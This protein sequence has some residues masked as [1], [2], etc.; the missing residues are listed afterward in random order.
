MIN[1]NGKLVVDEHFTEPLSSF[2]DVAQVGN[3]TVRAGGGTLALTVQPSQHTYSNAQI[4]DYRYDDFAFRW[5]PPL[6]M[7]V[8]A[9][10]S[11]AGRPL[12]GTQHTLND[13]GRT[14]N[15]TGDALGA[16]GRTLVGTAGFGFWNHPFSPDSRRLPH[17]P[18]AIWF[19]FASPPSNMAL[20]FGVPGAGWKAA[21]IDATRPSAIALAP[22]ALPAALL[23]RVPSLYARLY[24][25]IQ[26]R[27]KIAEKLLDGDLLAERHVY[28]LEWRADGARFAVDG[29]TVLQ[30]PF[31]PRGALGFVTWLD[32][33]YAI[34]TPQ[35]K[36]GFGIVPVAQE[37]TLLLEQVTIEPL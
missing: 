31:S 36:L 25:R 6:R 32:N 34:V 29:A 5:R 21:T 20:A 1:R 27:L 26:R 22:A 24:P 8:V 16:A 17:L 13:T 19:F 15:S 3:G 37:Q 4:A 23:M 12:S 30:T 11:A 10:A 18:Q 35:G 33:Q 14:L 9:R 7:T 2:W 28:T